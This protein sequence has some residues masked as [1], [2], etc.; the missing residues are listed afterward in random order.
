MQCFVIKS[1]ESNAGQEAGGYAQAIE[2]GYLLDCTA[3]FLIE[4]RE[5][6]S[7]MTPPSTVLTPPQQSLFKKMH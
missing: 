5:I 7:K 6:S 4:P 1:S 3:Y 2:G